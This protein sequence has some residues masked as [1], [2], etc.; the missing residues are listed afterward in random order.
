MKKILV[1]DDGERLIETPANPDIRSIGGRWLLVCNGNQV[2]RLARAG[3]AIR[4]NGK[5]VDFQLA[6]PRDR[7]RGDTSGDASGRKELR[8][9][10]PGKG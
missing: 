6:D 5:P 4:V 1:T 3:A 10:M 8:A 2:T 7:R 9:A